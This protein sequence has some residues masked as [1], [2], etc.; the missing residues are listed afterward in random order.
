MYIHLCSWEYYFYVTS[1]LK[2]S[3]NFLCLHCSTVVVKLLQNSNTHTCNI[4]HFIDNFFKYACYETTAVRR[5][6][7]YHVQLNKGFVETWLF[8]Y[9]SKSSFLVIGLVKSLHCDFCNLRGE[10]QLQEIFHFGI[11]YFSP[12]YWYLA[13]VL[14]M[15]AYYVFYVKISSFEI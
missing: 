10:W 8:V 3:T 5:D 15:E 11:K 6:I 13:T 2:H 12:L 7:V 4:T 14:K 9:F 1:I